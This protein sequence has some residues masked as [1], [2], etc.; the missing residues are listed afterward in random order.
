MIGDS[1]LGITGYNGKNMYLDQKKILNSLTNEDIIKIC[2][3]LGSPEYK[4][5]NQGNLLFSTSIC[6]DGDSPY[7][8]TYYNDSHRFKCWT[9]GD[10][11][12][13]IE[14]VIRAH[15]IK[16]KTLT[17]YRALYYIASMTGRLYEKDPEQIAPEKTITDFE[18][19][20]RLKSVKKNSKAVPNLTEINENILDIFWYAPYQGWLDEH[21]TREAMSRFEIGYYGLTNQITIPHR[22]INERLIGIRGRFLNDEDAERFGKYVPL[23]IGGRFLSHQLGSNLYGIHVAKD[24]IQQCKKVMLVEAEKSVLQAYSYFGEDSF[25]VG[26]CG[27]NISKTQIKIILEQL[28]VEE[29]I[30]GMDREY[31]DSDTFEATAYYQKLVKKVAPLVP[32]VRVYLVLDKEHRLDYKDSPTDK[33][34][35]IL[36]QLMKEKILVTMED[37]NEVI[38]RKD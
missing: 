28:K 30:V 36:L 4:R 31:G 3:D 26:L 38:K 27:S 34:K 14:L 13:I 23:Q 33:G 22:D 21:I 15:R 25:V 2:A 18:W 5:D 20:N 9:C 19:I 32:Y 10:S 6:H 29:V 35:D 1:L 12:G 16:G 24:K 7:K 11:Y 8:L 37:V 17:Y